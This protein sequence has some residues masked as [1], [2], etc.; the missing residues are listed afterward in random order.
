MH[1]LGRQ[2]QRI[3]RVTACAERRT[4]FF[5]SQCADFAVRQMTSAALTIRSRLMRVL[6]FVIFCIVTF[7]TILLLAESRSAL[8]LRFRVRKTHERGTTQTDK[9]RAEQQSL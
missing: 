4:G 5:K 2:I 9:H 8:N 6:A 7:K 1:K 3:G